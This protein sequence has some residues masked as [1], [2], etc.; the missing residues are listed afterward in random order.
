MKADGESRDEEIK[1]VTDTRDEK[2]LIPQADHGHWSEK[3]N[4]SL[5]R[6]S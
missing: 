3:E 6:T 2:E 5:Q 4:S 1:V